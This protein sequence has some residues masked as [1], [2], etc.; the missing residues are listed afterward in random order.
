[1]KKKLKI[2]SSCGKRIEFGK[3]CSCSEKRRLERNSYKRN[4]YDNNKDTI[5][6]LNNKRWKKL[7][8]VIISRDFGHCQRCAIKFGRIEKNNLQ[9][10]HI[11]PRFKYPELMYEESNLITLCQTCNLQLGTN[12]ELDFEPKEIEEDIQYNL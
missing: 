3:E 7:R 12:E 4:Y 6:M 10:H 11:K 2:C 5:K 1:M 8:K 9:V